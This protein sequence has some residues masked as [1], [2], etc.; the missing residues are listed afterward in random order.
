MSVICQCPSCKA[1]YQVGDQYA[2]HKIK[3]PKCGAAVHVPAAAP[4]VPVAAA[5]I[6]AGDD[7][8]DMAFAQSGD[9]NLLGFLNDDA[10][11]RKHHGERSGK[12]RAKIHDGSVPGDEPAGPGIGAKPPAHGQHPKKKKS[13]SGL[14]IAG[15]ACV[16][17]AIAGI[18][19]GEL[20]YMRA[21]PDGLPTA[22]E[23]KKPARPGVDPSVPMI[24][25][26]FKWP[27]SER[28][29]A[30]LTV[31]GELTPVPA[32]GEFKIMLPKL[33]QPYHFVLERKGFV[34]KEFSRPLTED[35]DFNVTQWEAENHGI[36]W[37]QD[38]AAARKAAADK[39]KNVLIVFD[40]SDAKASQYHSS[41][42]IEAIATNSEFAERAAKEYV[43]VYIDNP[44]KDEAKQKV[45][46]L[47]RNREFTKKFRITAFPTVVVTDKDARPFGIMEDY[48]IN[49]ITPFLALMDKWQKDRTT[50]FSLLDK[51]KAGGDKPDS[52]S[53]QEAISFLEFNRLDGIYQHTIQGW[54]A[55]LPKGGS[56]EVTEQEANLWM[57]RFAHAHAN[58]DNAKKEVAEFDRWKTRHSFRETCRH[59]CNAPRC[60]RRAAGAN[61]RKRGRQKEMRRSK[62]LP[63]EKCLC[64]AYARPGRA[65]RI[66]QGGAGR[67][68]SP[69]FRFGLLHRRRQLRHD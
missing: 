50:L 39:D 3:C 55:K 57:I 12:Q 16:C 27:E 40:A 54:A 35:D 26:T 62:S 65:H 14:L 58:P 45:H 64:P 69:R 18:I 51:I 24:G 8:G 11:V 48:T 1:K 5:S 29:G 59:R 67:G 46:D 13:T 19:G 37:E 17:L 47:N 7:N 61:R 28:S 60:R 38:F 33:L 31:N 66:G 68:I 9:D 49:G 20:Y 53:L 42:F 63:G 22:S 41:R 15:L 32:S 2:G 43:C 30:T 56:L 25:F 21:K 6:D 23:M 4:V 44:E 34:T 10:A 36:D 52:A